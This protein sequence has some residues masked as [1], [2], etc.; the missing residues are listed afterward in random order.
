[1]GL[2]PSQ[3]SLDMRDG[4][5]DTL[6]PLL[7]IRTHHHDTKTVMV[8]FDLHASESSTCK[9]ISNAGGNFEGVLVNP[10]A[11]RAWLWRTLLTT[12]S[13]R[14]PYSISQRRM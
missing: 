14:M 13:T 12:P 10:R 11:A 3:L 7:I 4:I 2:L 5:Q 8:A 1:L 9:S 6:R